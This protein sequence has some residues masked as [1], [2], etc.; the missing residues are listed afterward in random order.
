MKPA[1]GSHDYRERP[2]I[3]DLRDRKVNDRDGPITGRDRN[4]SRSMHNPYG[5]DVRDG[6]ESAEIFHLPRKR[7]ESCKLNVFL[8][9][10]RPV[11]EN[12]S[13]GA[14]CSGSGAKY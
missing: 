9:C 5:F 3:E 14:F 11:D 8:T 10:E 7:Q 2:R 13:C 4:S 6:N 12:L 1:F